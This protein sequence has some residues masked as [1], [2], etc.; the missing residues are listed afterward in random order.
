MA[1][2]NLNKK[3]IVEFVETHF[4]I[5]QIMLFAFDLYENWVKPYFESTEFYKF[6][7][8]N[9]LHQRIKQKQINLRII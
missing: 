8:I 5:I 3:A 1:I 7:V 2:L 6:K 9:L 4:E